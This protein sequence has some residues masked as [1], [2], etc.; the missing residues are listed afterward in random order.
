MSSHRRVG[1]W[2]RR[3]LPNEITGTLVSLSSAWLTYRF[4]DSLV[5]AA[6]AGTVGENIGF[7]GAA[8]ARN[9]RE[10]WIHAVAMISHRRRA[11]FQRALWFTV[12]EF[13]P[14]EVV[15]SFA[16]RP[17]L[18]YFAPVTVGIPVVGWIIGKILA[19][20]VFYTVAGVSY[21]ISRRR[22]QEKVV[23][24]MTEDVRQHV[25]NSIW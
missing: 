13:G 7:Y 2:I 20:A 14:A 16:V 3:Y 24:E 23:T 4:T 5:A 17:L 11:S 21:V 18:L 12:V 1:F 19:D 10:Q 6:V 15:D 25:Q 22:P 8:A 9:I